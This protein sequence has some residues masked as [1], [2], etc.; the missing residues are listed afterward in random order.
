M[1]M[2]GWGRKGITIFDYNVRCSRVRTFYCQF[3][4]AGIPLWE[5]RCPTE[6]Y[7][8]LMAASTLMWFSSRIVPMA[9][10]NA[11]FAFT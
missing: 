2:W 6:I 4:R 7:F 5:A 1:V 8:P 3:P 11:A 9:L 10:C